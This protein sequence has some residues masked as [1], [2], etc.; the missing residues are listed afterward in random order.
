MLD[1]RKSGDG[2]G[3]RQ[4]APG[5]TLVD[6]KSGRGVAVAGLALGYVALEAA[7]ILFFWIV[8]GSVAGAR[9]QVIR[10]S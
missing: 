7:L 9:R 2:Q 10:L 3:Q 5:L 1:G 8:V 4:A 6:A